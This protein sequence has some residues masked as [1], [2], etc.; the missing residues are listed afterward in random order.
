MVRKQRTE[1]VIKANAG[2]LTG[3][4]KSQTFSKTENEKTELAQRQCQKYKGTIHTDKNIQKKN[5]EYHT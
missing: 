5:R 1:Q 2:P 4:I 3:R